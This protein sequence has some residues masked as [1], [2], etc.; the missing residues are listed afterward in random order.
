MPG[1]GLEVLVPL[2]CLALSGCLL[3]GAGL[4][5]FLVKWGVIGRYW[6]KGEAA[7]QES[8]DYR[9]DQSQEV[10]EQKNS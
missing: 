3:L 1:L 10:S 5:F 7:V 4:A 6:L 9:L 2:A 8:G